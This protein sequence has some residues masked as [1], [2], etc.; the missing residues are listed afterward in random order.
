MSTFVAIDVETANG[1]NHSICQIGLAAF[2]EGVPLWAWQSLV[3][4]EEPF[5]TFNV[6]LHGIAQHHTT[7]APTF[8][9]AI[10]YL[11]NALENQIVACHW[12][13]DFDAIHAAAEKYDAKLPTATW[14]D[15]CRVSRLAWPHLDNHKLPTVCNHLDIPLKHHNAGSDAMACGHILHRATSELGTGLSDLLKNVG[16]IANPVQYQNPPR[17]SHYSEKIELKGRKDGPLA[18][19]VLVCTGEMKIG[20]SK[21]AEFAASL[22]CDVDENFTQRRTTILVTGFRDPAR[23]NGNPKSGKMID[24]EKAIAKGKKITIMT[25]AEFLEVA[26]R[27]GL[28]AA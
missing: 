13:F 18:G 12:R 8:P 23:F 19:H 17:N 6:K 16:T 11:R 24:A 22:G 2:R 5:D 4:P 10:E 7:W 20:E 14:I 21:I 9:V 28:A 27:F 3:N 1:S 15:T 26:K 25:E